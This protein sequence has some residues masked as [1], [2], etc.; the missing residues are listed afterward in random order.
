MR[1]EGTGREEDPEGGYKYGIAERRA[2]KCSISTSAEGNRPKNEATV[3]VRD[4]RLQA[5]TGFRVL[6]GAALIGLQILGASKQLKAAAIWSVASLE[7]GTKRNAD[8]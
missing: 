3:S 5:V 8:H 2:K 6:C 1:K 7:S 4:W